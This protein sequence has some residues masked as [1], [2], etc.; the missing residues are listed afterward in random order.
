MNFMVKTTSKPKQFVTDSSIPVKSFYQG[1]SKNSKKEEPGKYPFTRGI[2]A[3]MYRDRLWTMR[4]YSGFGNAKETN[5]R[6][7]FLLGKGQTGLSMAFDLP[8]QIGHDPDA[9]YAEGEV[10]KVGVSIASL[11]DM[12]TVFQGIKLGL[13][14]IHI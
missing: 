9:P 12:Q 7:K 5:K 13:S 10:G 8:T 14:L 2:H 6:F 3:G 11:K 4:Q 1:S